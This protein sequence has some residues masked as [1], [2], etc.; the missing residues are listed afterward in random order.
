M[1]SKQIRQMVTTAIIIALTIVFQYMRPLL[2]GTNPISTYIIGSLVNLCIVVA[3]CI[4]SVWSGIAV[5][6][7][8]PLIALAQG[9]AV[10]FMVPWIMIGNSV[11]AVSFGVFANNSLE[12]KTGDW[13]RYVI[14]GVVA[15]IIKFVVIALG[16]AVMLTSQKG[17]PI[18]KAIG[19]AAGA[20][21]QQIIT[22]VIGMVL[23][24]IVILALPAS[25]KG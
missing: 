5:S 24:K 10:I 15:S 16:Q 14:I 7:V 9:H 1:N 18:S 22:A 23:A 2:G 6:V 12:N 21:L 19:V 25:V 3:A 8:T 4:I 13:V 11:L 20:Q 17:A